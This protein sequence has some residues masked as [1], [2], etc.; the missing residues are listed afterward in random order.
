MLFVDAHLGNKRENNHEVIFQKH[1]HVMK[2]I[3]PHMPSNIAEIPIYF[4][5]CEQLLYKNIS[6]DDLKFNAIN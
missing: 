5:T 1:I 6:K 3:L 4:D 2:D